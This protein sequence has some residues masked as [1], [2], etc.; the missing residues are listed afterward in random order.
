MNRPE[1]AVATF[2]Q[3]FNCSQAVLSAYAAPLGLE[4]ETALRLAAGF[5]GG[6]GRRGE[7]CGAV[8][9]AIMVLGLKFC[10]GGTAEKTPEER[11]AE[12]EQV[13]Q[14]VQQF[15]AGFQAR[16]GSIVCRDLLGCDISQPGDY[17]RAR[18]QQLFITRC[19]KF[20][21]SAA[22]ALEELL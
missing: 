8:T 3:G 14:R 7:T 22:E 5:G 21:Q 20:V 15:I 13:Y 1:V 17:Q 12:R 9:G 16:H 4:R 10:G 11:I 18:A 2:K 19:P 6:L